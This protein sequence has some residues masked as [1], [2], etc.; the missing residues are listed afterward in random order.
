VVAL[1]NTG[2]GDAPIVV[3]MSSRE[4]PS[5]SRSLPTGTVT[6]LFTDIEG[7][8]LLLQRVGDRYR[9][10]LETHQDL[11]RS[12]I[13]AGD[14]IEIH[15]EGDSFFV[16]FES[17][18]GA[19]DAAVAAQRALTAFAW[20][21]GEEIRVRMG[22][23]T[24]EGRLGGDNY[25]GLDVHRTA[26][27]SSIAHGGQVI[28]SDVTATL[29][30]DALPDGVRLRDLGALRLKDLAASEHLHQLVVGGL[31]DDFPP[32]RSLDV[33]PHRLPT[34]LST[35]V[36]RDVEMNQAVTLLRDTRLLTLTGPGGTGKTRLAVE[37]AR[38]I[39]DE[40]DDG[41]FFVPLA[42]IR[43][44]SRIPTAI[45]EAMGI[46]QLAAGTDP[47]SHLVGYL[48]DK[49]VLLV[50]DNFEQVLDAAPRVAEVLGASPRSRVI[51]TSRAPLRVAGEQELP[52]PPLDVP[53]T[54]GD[55]SVESGLEYSGVA[56]FAERA[57]SVR[58]DFVLTRDNVDAVAELT[59]RLDGLPLAIEL[60]AA[61]AKIFPPAAILDRLGSRLLAG[62]SRDLPE[63]QRTLRDTIGWSYDLLDEPT[64][65]LFERF[66]VFAGGAFVGQIEAVCAR[67]TQDDVWN[68]LAALVDQ[69]L[70]TQ[71][72]VL[73]E[74]RFRMLA[75]IHEYA[76]ERFAERDDAEDLRRTHAVTYLALALE[77]GPELIRKRRA[78]W[79]ERLT[80]EHANLAKAL[81]WATAAPDPEM[82]LRF[83]A[84][85]WRFWQMR[86]HLRFATESIE[87]VLDLDGGSDTARAAALE[88]AGGIA[89]WRGDLDGQLRAYRKAS[90]LWRKIGDEHEIANADY[91]LAYPV[92]VAE[93]FLAGKALLDEAEAI[94]E[95]LG[96]RHGMGRVHWARANAW[97]LVGEHEK[98][99]EFCCRSI[100]CFDPDEHP[101]DLGW[102]EFVLAENL[103]RLGR[104]DEARR[105]LSAGLALF[106]EVDD[107]SAMVLFIGAFA[108][109]AQVSGDAEGAF[110]L[111]GA[112]DSLR[113]ET[114]TDF[115]TTDPTR[116]EF[117]ARDRIDR[118]EG[119]EL[120]AFE[121]GRAM[122]LHEAVGYATGTLEK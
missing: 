50:L 18:R 114:G 57:R 27:I 117:W 107:L 76:A 108:E 15:T 28:V 111:F 62:G 65:R 21:A 25:V 31:R 83:A 47:Q 79:L 46:R 68:G 42:V 49:E 36:E 48:Q 93:G 6:F 118:L 53:P 39:A 35:F 61:K 45:L 121:E 113:R 115:V 29:V 109:A 104:R 1:R 84:S 44:G 12:A 89:Y 17:A 2:V 106:R 101:F 105:H 38:N 64:R 37:V 78:E 33:T 3:A 82:A 54:G 40:Y 92:A 10:L 98:A 23:H 122:S 94:Y 88:A 59:A 26:R 4:V 116:S 67:G 66:A 56:L 43:D 87:A 13:S 20:P 77:A 91:N 96:D 74:P 102:A 30:T 110:R 7:S 103:S 16:V 55:L 19:V 86:G 24:G 58:P 71:R 90:A 80:V 60:A 85:L 5:R 99:V 22:M 81:A 70:V 72:D 11:V 51:A 69:S 34:Y 14:G 63:R 52:V 97:Q 73:G 41:A 95:S 8:T 112:M 100:E 119:S 75:T 32:L 120:V 9:D